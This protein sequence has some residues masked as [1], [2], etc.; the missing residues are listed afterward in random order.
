MGVA[1]VRGPAGRRPA[2]PEGGRLRQALR[3]PQ[4]AGADRHGFDAVVGERDLRETYLPAF[5]A[6][7]REA[8]VESVM[9]AYNRTN[10]EAC[11]AS[12]TLLEK[13]LRAGVGL[14][15]LRRLRLRRD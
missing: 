6:L 1:F 3:R 2:L 12:P 9:G 5:E 15:R 13:I 4:R 7:V 14:R 10:G 8:K 11:C